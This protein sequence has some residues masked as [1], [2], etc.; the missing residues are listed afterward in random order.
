M[1]QNERGDPGLHELRRAS[2][3][4]PNNV[5][6]PGDFSL[7]RVGAIDEDRGLLDTVLENGRNED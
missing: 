1:P 4:L 2:R 5:T 7:E 3:Q 6:R